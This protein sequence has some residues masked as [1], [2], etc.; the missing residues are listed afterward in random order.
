MS[1]KRTLHDLL[2]ITIVAC[3]SGTLLAASCSADSL[4]ALSVG[5]D[6]AAGYLNAQPDA[7]DDISFGDWLADE[8][9][10]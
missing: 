4:Q 5:V 8:L 1:R 2:K 3:A 9:K 7:D 6:A 10:D